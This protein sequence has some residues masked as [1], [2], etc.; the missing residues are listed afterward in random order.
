MNNINLGFT[1][2]LHLLTLIDINIDLGLR[3]EQD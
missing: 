3:F 2:D 1:N